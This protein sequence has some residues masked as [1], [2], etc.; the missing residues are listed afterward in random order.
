MPTLPPLHDLVRS[1][2]A[3]L[4]VATGIAAA[5]P[6]AAQDLERARALYETR[7]GACHERSVHRRES[8]RA[9]DFATLRAEVSRWNASA[10][11]E[12]RSEEID[13]VTVYLNRLYYSF[14]CP[15]EH[16]PIA[17]RAASQR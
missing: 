5:L 17:P 2:V 4:L 10:G 6:A 1:L 14:P 12:W 13:L 7:C 16:C 15:P 3:G 9:T 8:R 11:S